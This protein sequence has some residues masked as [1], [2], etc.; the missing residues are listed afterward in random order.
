[1]SQLCQSLI[2]DLIKFVQL[3]WQVKGFSNNWCPGILTKRA[4]IRCWYLR[5]NCEKASGRICTSIVTNIPRSFGKQHKRVEE[6]ALGPLFHDDIL[7]LWFGVPW[8]RKCRMWFLPFNFFLCCPLLNHYKRPNS[9]LAKSIKSLWNL[10][11]TWETG[12]VGK[13]FRPSIFSSSCYQQTL[14]N[15]IYCRHKMS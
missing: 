9:S 12:F 15:F 13:I 4:N 7:F 11:L 3:C 1:M 10:Y 2:K 8:F 14:I 6:F 5:V